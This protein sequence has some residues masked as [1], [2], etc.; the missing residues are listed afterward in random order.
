MSPARL[1][2]LACLVSLFGSTALAQPPASPPTT[3]STSTKRTPAEELLDKSLEKLAKL[4]WME[5]TFKHQVYGK[6][7]LYD[8]TGTHIVAPPEKMVCYETRVKLGNATGLLR[9]QCDGETVWRILQNG[10]Q[11]HVTKYSL[12]E[13][14]EARG[15][16]ERG[17]LGEELSAQLLRDD[18]S[19]HGFLGIQPALLELKEKMTFPKMESATLD[20]RPVQVL[21]GEWT[22]S[23]LDKVVPPRKE[24]ASGADRREAWTKRTGFPGFPRS[25]KV[26]LGRE[27][28]WPYRIEWYGPV[29]PEGKDER[30]VALDYS[31]PKLEKPGSAATAKLFRPSDEELEKA[32]AMDAS[33]LITNR[34]N[35]LKQLK[36]QEEKALSDKPAF[37][38]SFTPKKP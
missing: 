13:R 15:K 1:I 25:C 16:I 27:N 19:E 23:Y 33:V 17:R 12:K 4:P 28:L 32:E 18:D 10:D 7:L 6:G 21:E 5:T 38:P 31:E 11:K 2:R 35:T 20:G 8:A 14:D 34:Q 26:Y 22:K 37:D 36:A 30:L 9:I 3:S 29:M 24:G